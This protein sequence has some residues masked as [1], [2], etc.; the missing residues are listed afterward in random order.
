MATPH[1]VRQENRLYSQVLKTVV[2]EMGLI[3]NGN[4]GICA[5]A[6]PWQSRS[7][8][9]GDRIRRRLTRSQARALSTGDDQNHWSRTVCRDYYVDLLKDAR[10]LDR[11]H[12]DGEALRSLIADHMDGRLNAGAELGRLASVEHFGR[13]WIDGWTAAGSE[14]TELAG[15]QA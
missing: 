14:G 12:W 10:T 1:E 3:P 8:A 9:V 7:H 4:T 6:T 5:D 2:P 15:A 13:R 11:P